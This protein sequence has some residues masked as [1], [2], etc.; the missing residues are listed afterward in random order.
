MK[1]YVVTNNY[2]LDTLTL[3]PHIECYYITDG[4]LYEETVSGEILSL[5]KVIQ[6]SDIRPETLSANFSIAT[7]QEG[8]I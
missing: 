8:E 6:E 4:H 1:R 7:Y 3:R 2:I 5:G